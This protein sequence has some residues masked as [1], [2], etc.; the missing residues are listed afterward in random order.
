LV[1][2]LGVP[3]EAA[4]YSLIQQVNEDHTAVEVVS[5]HG[6]AVILSKADY[7]AMTETAYLLRHPANAE[8]LLSALERARP[9]LEHLGARVIHVG[10]T[11]AG[12]AAKALNNL[13]SA[14]HLLATN[15]ALI[16]GARFGIEPEVL[17]AAINVSSGRSGP[18]RGA[19]TSSPGRTG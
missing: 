14:T 17:N 9:L 3:V 10:A 4:I 16:V 15:E 1:V 6:N 18:T 2:E 13:L 12:H 5:R 7:D 11:G 8:R 19:A